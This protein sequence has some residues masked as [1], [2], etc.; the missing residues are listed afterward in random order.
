MRDRSPEKR[1]GRNRPGREAAGT[2]CQDQ[3]GGQG[4]REGARGAYYRCGTTRAGNTRAGNTAGCRWD[5]SGERLNGSRAAPEAQPGSGEEAILEQ[6][7]RDAA[8]IFILVM[9]IASIMCS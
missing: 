1:P 3:A 2:A 7:P 8:G 6:T 4:Y 9:V 5:G